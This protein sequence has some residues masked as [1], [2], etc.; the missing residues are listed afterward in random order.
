MKIHKKEDSIMLMKSMRVMRPWWF[1]AVFLAALALTTGCHKSSSS[2]VTPETS[3]TTPTTPE[4][5]TTPTTP[6]NPGEPL[7]S[8]TVGE[9]T[10][11]AVTG[12]SAPMLVQGNLVGDASAALTGNPPNTIGNTKTVPLTA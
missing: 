9:P 6:T 4:T 7:T 11:V 12:V 3:S 5:P 8:P 2:D 10:G 1:I